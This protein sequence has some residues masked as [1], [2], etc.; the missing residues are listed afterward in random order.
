[1]RLEFW[2][3]NCIVYIKGI[4]FKF[5]ESWTFMKRISN[6]YYEIY[7]KSTLRS[8]S[9]RILFSGLF[10]VYFMIFLRDAS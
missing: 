2:G 1:M 10:R 3:I 7:F 8:L 9:T 5:L 4:R 6:E